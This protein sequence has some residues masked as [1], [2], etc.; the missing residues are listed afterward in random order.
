MKPQVK[1]SQTLSIPDV[2]FASTQIRLLKEKNLLRPENLWTKWLIKLFI[3][4]LRLTLALVILDI[5]SV[6]LGLMLAILLKVYFLVPEPL[7]VYIAPFVCYVIYL[8][9]ILYLNS[10]YSLFKDKRPEIA[11]QEII[12]SNIYA[13]ILILATNFIFSKET[14]YSRYVFLCGFLLTSCFLIFF[15]FGLRTF[16]KYL[17]AQGYLKQNVIIVGNSAAHLKWLLDLLNI[18]KFSGFNILGY[19][20]ANPLDKP[21]PG[22]VYL[23]SFEELPV[24]SQKIPIDK[25]FFAMLYSSQRHQKLIDRL[26]I[27]SR[28]KIPALIVSDIFN[29]FHFSL[30][31]DGYTGVFQ[32]TRPTPGYDG[33]VYSFIKRLLDILASLFLL[34]FSLPVWTVAMA[35]IKWQDGGPIFFRHTLVGKDGKLFDM[36]KFRTMIVNAQQVLENDPKLLKAYYANYKIENDPRITP[37]G[38]WLRKTSL[39]ELPQLINILKGDMSL[40]GPRPVKKDELEK[41]GNFKD[42]RIKVRPGLTGFWQV[43]G[44]CNTNY[45]ERMQMDRFYMNKCSIWLDLVILLKTPLKVLKSD[46]AM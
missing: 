34:L 33:P 16:L 30:T 27:C 23:G 10:G 14:I 46:G 42:E 39:D 15:R 31:L 20:A 35:V 25:I 9:S 43:S 45:A 29:N 19:L 1:I 22:M 11:L 2:E 36:L 26:E 24:I 5:L 6:S 13:F 37:I 4:P 8:I 38:K 17:W 21:I 40:V 44:R 41:F 28:L 3:K 7:N 32:V 18:Q 12:T